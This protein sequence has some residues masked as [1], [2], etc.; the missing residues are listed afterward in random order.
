MKIVLALAV[1]VLALAPILASANE[2]PTL[3]A[4]IDKALGSRFDAQAQAARSMAAQAMSLHQAGKH[5]ESVKMYDAA[6][7]AGGLTLTHKK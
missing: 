7:K 6:A 1:A 2:C 5:A 3:Q 4:Q